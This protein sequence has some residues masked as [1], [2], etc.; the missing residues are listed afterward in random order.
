MVDVTTNDFLDLVRQSGL[1]EPAQLDTFLGVTPELP[2]DTPSLGAALIRAGLLT[3]WHVEQ[4]RER[5]HKGFFLGKYKLLEHLGSGG[6]G[7]VY[8]AEHRVMRR[9]V[10][11]K[12]LAA[13]RVSK[14]SVYLNRFHQEARAVAALDH[15]NVVQ[16]YD[17][18]QDGEH[19]YLVME[20]V[21]GTNCQLLVRRK[22]P[23]DYATAADYIR[24]A[25]LGLEHAHRAGLVHRD[26]KPA[27]LLVDRR[28]VVKIVDLGLARLSDD[29]AASLTLQ[30]DK[31]KVIGTV[32]YMAPEQALDSHHVDHRVDI[33]SLGC[34]LYYL[35]TGRPPFP[36][37]SLPQRIMAHHT[38]QPPD[39][40]LARPDAPEPLLAICAKMMAKAPADRFGSCAELAELLESWVRGGA[41]VIQAAA[42]A[43]PIRDED[44]ALAPLDGEDEPAG[45]ESSPSSPS[46][47]HDPAPSPRRAGGDSDPGASRV[48][49]HRPGTLGPS[50]TDRA[51]RAEAAQDTVRSAASNSS[52]GLVDDLLSEVLSQG[53]ASSIGRR[54]DV[55]LGAVRAEALESV[56]RR[57]S[58][59]PLDAERRESGH[60]IWFLVGAG[61]LLALVALAIGIAALS[62][63]DLG[64]EQRIERKGTLDQ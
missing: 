20:Y 31:K 41:V 12:V 26:V 60:S 4:L 36:D 3:A 34:T 40:R 10:A 51:V 17:V 30:M 54:S 6:M 52:A 7:S 25:A 47:V 5:R 48:R 33:Y 32:D 19:H 57:T 59:P 63:A 28:G 44:L 16:A 58:K 37:G 24:Q 38:K 27:N 11:I 23:L 1:V 49:Y 42:A 50:S 8:L 21:D 64:R 13:A 45:S 43:K 62:T 35:L 61:A 39:V 22:G 15:P 29:E 18:D 2:E 55:D 56:Q 46:G 14:S 53:P 9:R